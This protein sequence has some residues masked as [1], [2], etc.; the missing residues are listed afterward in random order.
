MVSVYHILVE[1]AIVTPSIMMKKKTILA[2]AASMLTALCSY[3][4]DPA[5]DNP[6]HY[7]NPW[8]PSNPKI[9]LSA[10]SLAKP[11]PRSTALG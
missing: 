9:G 3:A 7:T 6:S 2:L 4:A 5:H 10:D 11:V 8:G 1:Y